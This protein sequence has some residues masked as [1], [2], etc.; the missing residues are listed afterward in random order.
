MNALVAGLGTA[1]ALAGVLL[2]I[3]ALRRQPDAETPRRPVKGR[4]ALRR[5][6]RQAQSRLAL[7]VVGGVIA[8]AVSGIILTIVI[9]PLAVFGIPQL[10][11]KQSTRE[12][13]LLN[14][15]EIWARSLAG[16]SATDR[17][18]LMEAIG[19]SRGSVPELLQL[20]VDRMYLR[21]T[22]SWSEAEALRAFAT[23]L[24]NS[25]VDEV[26]IYLIQAAEGRQAGLRDAL[27]GIADNLSQQV[28][29]RTQIFQEREKPRRTLLAMTAITVAV[30]ALVVVTAR[31][32]QFQAFASPIGQLILGAAVAAFAGLLL[33]SKRIA[34][35]VPEPRIIV[36]EKVP[37]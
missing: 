34:K 20:P 33:W 11:G 19:I 1:I 10:I 27:E 16:A 3:V 14:A 30:V 23:E 2:L 36:T 35:T 32:P 25:W 15:L 7:G 37:A 31:F 6:D 13:D 26:T 29:V 22:G 12:R 24:D 18:S 9:V 28:D 8:A 4:A 21:M 17:L 5:F